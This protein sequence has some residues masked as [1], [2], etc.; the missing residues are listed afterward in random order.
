MR[1]VNLLPPDLRRTVKTAA[2]RPAAPAPSG[3]GAFLV[4]GALALA[5]VALAGYVL[6]TNTVRQ[7]EAEL[8]DVSV[9]Q[10]ATA[11]RAA[12]LK[13]YADFQALSE[14][15]VATVRDLAAKR[16]DWEM[17]LRDLSRAIPADVTLLKLDGS[18]SSASSTGGNQLRGALDVPAIEL[19]GCTRDQPSVARLM[20]RLRNVDGVTRVSLAKS[21]KSEAQGGGGESAV[22]SGPGVETEAGPCGQGS[23]P[24]FQ[25][26][27][28]FER[29]ADKSA[30]PT[31][32]AAGGA[33]ATPAATTG[34]ASATATPTPSATPESSAAITSTA[35]A[36]TP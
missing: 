7:R 6:T 36:S 4:L 17:A 10:T 32:P 30:A 2:R 14:A 15:R 26:V 12:Q 27:A 28:F 16:F 22:A 34:A 8:A 35:G 19:E 31:G 11:A 20:S 24:S 23:P 33:E 21:S 25:I 29:Q 18:V 3:P 9:R 5:V 1:A 13:P